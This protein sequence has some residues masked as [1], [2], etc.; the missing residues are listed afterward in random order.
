LKY[1]PEIDGL[2]AIAVV[3]VILFHAGF[4]LFSG[5]FVG[6]D[7]FFVI[8]GYLITSIIIK[9][10]DEGTFS[11][12]NFYERRAR[13]I[14]PALLFVVLCCITVAWFVLLPSDMEDFAQSIVAVATF[15]SNILFW[16]ESGYFDTAAELKP[17]L[18][19]WS[20]AVEEQFYILYPLTLLFLWKFGERK[21]LW[22]MIIGLVGSLAVAH[23]GAYNKPAATFYLLPT[24]G[25]E[26]LIGCIIAL[27]LQG[28]AIQASNLIS[29]TLAAIGLLMIVYSVFAFDQTTPFPSLYAL[30]PTIGTALIILYARP[31]TLIH[32]VLTLKAF[33]GIGLISYSAYLWHQPLLA[34][35]RHAQLETPTTL[36]T[37]LIIAITFGLSVISWKFIELPARNKQ[38]FA[39]KNVLQFSSIFFIG[40]L[41]TGFWGH[42]N[43][44]FE[45]RFPSLDLI[46]SQVDNWQDDSDCYFSG[47]SF[48]DSDLENCSSGK[49]VYLVGDS[50]AQ[51]ISRPLRNILNEQG[52]ELISLTHNACLPI[53]GVSRLPIAQHSSCWKF[54]ERVFSIL[55]ER[56]APVVLIS[57]W[58]LNIDGNRYDNG[59]GGIEKGVFAKNFVV[60]DD[61][62]DLI[63]H[64]VEYLATIAEKAPV[65]VVDQIP[66][67]GWDVFKFALRAKAQGRNDF[68]LTTS[69]DVYRQ[70]NKNVFDFLNKASPYV[71]IIESHK[72]ICD[73]LSGRCQNFTGNI[74]LYRDD[75]HPANSFSEM[76]SKEIHKKLKPLLN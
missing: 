73:N 63:D 37:T 8:S 54:K 51:S 60:R 68:D 15:S 52:Y 36:L 25:W 35:V 61:Q 49:F 53:T 18:H 38:I 7:V 29:N 1:R 31:G 74:P 47:N 13:R 11:L 22:L 55:V 32:S 69:F 30:L 71:T 72:L 20:L 3:P 65:L 44:G 23:W 21:I 70:K 58:R 43:K 27:Y 28:R 26:L 59:E 66:E 6:V 62:G 5:G 42:W 39:S 17:L 9:D 2:R 14:L 46:H 45:E 57:R 40:L 41:T 56:P 50:H 34:F 48:S 24:R 33:V 76:I 10:M 19:T 16:R 4:E 12:L 67:A 64:M 75:D